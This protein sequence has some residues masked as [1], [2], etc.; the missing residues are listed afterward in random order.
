MAP[1]NNPKSALT[2]SMSFIQEIV[3]QPGCD[4]SF[5]DDSSLETTRFF[6]RT[7]RNRKSDCA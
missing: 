4:Y 7:W 6:N 3:F 5:A 1:M 2:R